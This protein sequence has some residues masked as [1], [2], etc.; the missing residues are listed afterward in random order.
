MIAPI[1]RPK[2]SASSP[3]VRRARRLVASTLMQQRPRWPECA[4]SVPAW[5]AWMFTA[6]VVAISAAYFAYMVGLL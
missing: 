4:P 3:G 2:A 1:E 5:Q 6:W